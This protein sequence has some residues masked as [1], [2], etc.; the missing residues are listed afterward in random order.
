MG[1]FWNKISSTGC[2]W[3]TLNA[4]STE[5]PVSNSLLGGSLFSIFSPCCFLSG[6]I[7]NGSPH[8]KGHEG[9][10]ILERNQ[11]NRLQIVQFECPKYRN[12]YGSFTFECLPFP[13]FQR[14]S[15]PCSFLSSSLFWVIRNGSPQYKG[16]EGGN[17]FVHN[18][19][20]RIQK[21]QFECPRVRNPCVS[22]TLREFPYHHFPLFHLACVAS[23][24][25]NGDWR[26][27]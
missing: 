22:S 7:R 25:T 2:K 12:P 26:S 13:H 1:K 5:I 16:Q 14:I 24:A 11:L 19:L 6:V 3:S 18:Q 27:R 15:S 9:G 23:V 10:N 17:I 21:F 20:N 8:Y 4:P